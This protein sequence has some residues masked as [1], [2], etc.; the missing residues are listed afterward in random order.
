MR[1]P[2]CWLNLQN[3]R[4]CPSIYLLTEFYSNIKYFRCKLCLLQYIYIPVIERVLFLYRV[5]TV[6][7]KC[8]IQHVV[9][10]MADQSMDDEYARISNQNK[11]RRIS[12]SFAD[13]S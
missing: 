12:S 4:I 1:H 3:H 9:L 7:E 5:S 13:V 8:Y 6:P 2:V 11:I 10:C